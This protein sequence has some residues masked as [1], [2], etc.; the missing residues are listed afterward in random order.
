MIRKLIVI[1][2]LTLLGA[3]ALFW[4]YH[5]VAFSE[6]VARIMML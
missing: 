2:A 5:T 1:G 6:Q 3:S 4:A